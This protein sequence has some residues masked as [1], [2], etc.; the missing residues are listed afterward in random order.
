MIWINDGSTI[1]KA[2]TNGLRPKDPNTKKLIEEELNSNE[3]SLKDMKE[4]ENLKT[5]LKVMIENMKNCWDTNPKN[6]QSFTVVHESLLSL[7]SKRNTSQTKIAIKP[8]SSQILEK[9]EKENV[10]ISSRYLWTNDDLNKP[11][12]ITCFTFDL[13]ESN[14]WFG[15]NDG[16]FISIYF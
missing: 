12:S 6:R 13:K 4:I 11:A 15:S 2:I 8:R 10:I 16:I 3:S 7:I 1:Q 14:F 5:I 9:L